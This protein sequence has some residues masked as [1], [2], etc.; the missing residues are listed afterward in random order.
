LEAVKQTVDPPE[1]RED[2][3]Y[4]K[5]GANVF[6]SATDFARRVNIVS[7]QHYYAISQPPPGNIYFFDAI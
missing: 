1:T 4:S 6:R 3:S 5:I 2:L 7:Q